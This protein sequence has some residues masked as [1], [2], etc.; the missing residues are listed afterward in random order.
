MYLTHTKILFPI[1]YYINTKN[2]IILKF[3]NG[4][5]CTANTNTTWSLQLTYESISFH[6]Y[7]HML[8][9]GPYSIVKCCHIV[10]LSLS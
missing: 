4:D 9:C 6:K 3:V 2:H 5:L 8:I 1:L 10:K 7:W